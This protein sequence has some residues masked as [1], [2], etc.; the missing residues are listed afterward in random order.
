MSGANLQASAIF[1]TYQAYL[2]SGGRIHNPAPDEMDQNRCATQNAMVTTTGPTTAPDIRTYRPTTL[3]HS[4][5]LLIRGIYPVGRDLDTK[6]VRGANTNAATLRTTC[7]LDND[8][9]P[10]RT[11]ITARRRLSSII[12]KLPIPVIV[13]P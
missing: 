8:K 1:S 3:Y 10:A 2:E 7:S 5:G 4:R 12:V 11:P 9:S 6:I 13:R